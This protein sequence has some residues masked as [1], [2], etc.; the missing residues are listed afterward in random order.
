[1]ITSIYIKFIWLSQSLFLAKNHPPTNIPLPPLTRTLKRF[2][3]LF[4]SL[5][6][7]H[8]GHPC[9]QGLPCPPSLRSGTLN[10]LQVPP[11]LT[12]LLDTLLIEISTQNFQGIFLGV[13]NYVL[14]VSGQEPST[15]SKYPPSR[16]PFLT[17]F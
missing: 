4:M 7:I 3:S 2:S 5:L 16:P 10:V 8:E 1:M 9:C 13:N 12:P 11:F 15:S 17:P 14:H 6:Y